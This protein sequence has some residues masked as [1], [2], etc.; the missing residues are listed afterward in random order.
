MSTPLPH[1]NLP[2]AAW[3]SILSPEA[4][5]QITW[6]VS[7]RNTDFPANTNIRSV[8]L[9][10]CVQ[11]PTALKIM[12]FF[13]LISA[14]SIVGVRGV[15][16]Q[17]SLLWNQTLQKILQLRLVLESL[18]RASAHLLSARGDFGKLVR[19]WS[20]SGNFPASKAIDLQMG[21]SP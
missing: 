10:C 20:L 3:I 11:M 6:C 21:P 16:A 13:F 19:V 5:H 8:D 7:S 9:H 14:C 18:A 4:T 2:N 1:R 12:R 15:Y 17:N